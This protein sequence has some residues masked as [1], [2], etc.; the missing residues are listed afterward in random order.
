MRPWSCSMG[1]NVG[2]WSRAL[3]AADPRF[4]VCIE[5][6]RTMAARMRIPNAPPTHP[7]TIA[8][9]PLDFADVGG[10][11]VV[12]GMVDDETTQG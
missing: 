7:A 6:F 11:T 3:K 2:S 10:E 12:E 8:A 9:F 4:L 1:I 5:Y